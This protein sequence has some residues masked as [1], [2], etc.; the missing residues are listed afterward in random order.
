[1]S[2]FKFFE[3]SKSEKVGPP[4]GDI[5]S[6]AL[7]LQP[8]KNQRFE[9]SYN[10]RFFAMGQMVV[11]VRTSTIWL[12]KVIDSFENGTL[13]DVE[14]EDQQTFNSN[15]IMNEMQDFAK[16]FNY[17]TKMLVIKLMSLG[18]IERVLNQEEIFSRWE[19][20]KEEALKPLEK[21]DTDKEILQKG[22]IQFSDTL[23]AL[24]ETLLYSIFFGAFYG[25]KTVG[26]N[27]IVDTGEYNSQLFQTKSIPFEL[28]EK[29]TDIKPGSINITQSASLINDLQVQEE[30]GKLYDE[31]YKQ[32]CGPDF[33]YQYKLLVDYNIDSTS[34]LI[35]ECNASLREKA[36]DML[37]YQADYTIKR[38]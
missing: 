4:S 35:N 11:D 10:I 20:I 22:D 32:I 29:V 31:M 36:N 38:I 15:P 16:A 18:K 34:G 26:D 2:V 13:V 6:I 14:V 12:L 30:F 23:P 33:N 21:A 8:N 37:Y 28:K 3:E 7:M 19:E 5:R 17:P 25:T 24:K 9:I 27:N 1:M